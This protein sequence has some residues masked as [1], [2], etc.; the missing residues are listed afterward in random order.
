M[1]INTVLDIH[2]RFIEVDFS[3][4]IFN[5]VLRCVGVVLRIFEVWNA[6]L[7]IAFAVVP[8]VIVGRI[9]LRSDMVVLFGVVLGVIV[10]L[11]VLIGVDVLAINW[12]LF[13]VPG[14][15][16]VELVAGVDDIVDIEMMETVIA[17]V[18]FKLVVVII[19]VDVGANGVVVIVE[20]C[21]TVSDAFVGRVI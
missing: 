10:T 1:H 13:F 16:G 3:T 14:S 8:A 21:T 9:S 12:E 18:G 4:V 11:T 5:L 2:T 19:T 17:C 6:K 15:K 7:V 20:F